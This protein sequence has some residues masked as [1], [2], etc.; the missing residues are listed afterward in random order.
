LFKGKYQL[1]NVISVDEP[2]F[3]RSK[4][5]NEGVKK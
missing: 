3:V 1:W 4:W 5:Q 2:I